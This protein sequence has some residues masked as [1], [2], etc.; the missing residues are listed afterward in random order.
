MA[1][2]LPL[3]PVDGQTFMIGQQ[4][5]RFS[6][7]R[8]RWVAVGYTLALPGGAQAGAVSGSPSCSLGYF[9]LP[10]GSTSQRGAAT[11]GST[12]VN[13]QLN[14][15]EVYTGSTW[16]KI[17]GVG[18]SVDLLLVG[19]G[20][21]GSPT[22]G[23]G[24]GGYL[25]IGLIPLT[26]GSAYTITV[27]NGGAGA[28]GNAGGSSSFVNSTTSVTA[29]TAA[30]GTSAGSGAAYTPSQ[31]LGFGY[32][33]SPS[34]GGAGSREPG[35]GLA[36]GSGSAWSD[37]LIYAAGGST[38]GPAGAANTGNGGSGNNLGGSGVVKIRYSGTQQ[39]GSGGTTS[40]SGGYFYHTF[41]SSGGYF[42]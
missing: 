29:Y 17:S 16:T 3:N 13:S 33:S 19:G 22:S 34:G 32:A 37:G 38:T 40:T 24:S 11:T 20:G 7:A 9:A 6:V 25:A 8:S 41:T 26:R 28:P 27:G 10:V 21:G 36:G 15:I 14:Q 5:Y 12:R 42:A 35:H 4:V 23:G 31:T 18:Y 2:T 1:F 30:G 39:I